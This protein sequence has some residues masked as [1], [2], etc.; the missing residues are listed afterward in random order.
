M[1]VR[2]RP[3]ALFSLV[4]PAANDSIVRIRRKRRAVPVGNGSSI[5]VARASSPGLS[6]PCLQR[7]LRAQI[8]RGGKNPGPVDH[9]GLMTMRHWITS[10]RLLTTRTMLR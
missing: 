1:G 10:F 9:T 3:G 5:V 8:L 2:L 7:T 6:E 4:G